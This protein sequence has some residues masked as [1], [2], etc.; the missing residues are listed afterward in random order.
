MNQHPPPDHPPP[1]FCS[2][3]EGLVAPETQPGI[4]QRLDAFLGLAPLSS[5]SPTA[6]AGAA[7]AS[8]QTSRNLQEASLALGVFNQKKDHINPEGWPM[9]R[10]QYQD[11][12]ERIKPDAQ[13]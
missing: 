13:E 8:S 7:S 11:L 6:G 4:L 9:S 5:S 1:P 10:W 12:V 3:Y 2:Q